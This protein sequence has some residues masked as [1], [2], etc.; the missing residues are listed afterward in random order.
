[1]P[2]ILPIIDPPEQSAR[3]QFEATM[4]NFMT[5]NNDKTQTQVPAAADVSIR[6]RESAENLRL[7]DQEL[8]E[9]DDE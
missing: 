7:V 3:S 2:N 4:S 8:N 1:M 9:Y 6:S 5:L